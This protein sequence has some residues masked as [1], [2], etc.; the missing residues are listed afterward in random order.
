MTVD[1]LLGGNAGFARF[2]DAAQAGAAHAVGCQ[3]Q[4]EQLEREQHQCKEG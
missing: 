4:E 3:H 1:P 2:L